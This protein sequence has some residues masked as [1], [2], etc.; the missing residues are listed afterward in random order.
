MPEIM[1]KAV[2]WLL[3]LAFSLSLSSVALA[4]DG[5]AGHVIWRG[6]AVYS[7]TEASLCI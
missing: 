4:A 7:T 3:A 2:V 6:D 1:K 5:Q